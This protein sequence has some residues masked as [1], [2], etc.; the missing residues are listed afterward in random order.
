MLVHVEGNQAELVP[1]LRVASF[2]HHDLL[3]KSRS[4]DE[5]A[6]LFV[7][8][9]LRNQI[10]GRGHAKRV[11]RGECEIKRASISLSHTPFNCRATPIP[12]GM[13]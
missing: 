6:R 11:G 2:G 12:A 8:E 13:A 4:L 7:C 1:G 3:K 5:T 9:S 10:A